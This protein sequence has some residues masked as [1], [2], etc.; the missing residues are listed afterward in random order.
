MGITRSEWARIFLWLVV[1]SSV[2][3]TESRAQSGARVVRYNAGDRPAEQ[4]RVVG[5]PADHRR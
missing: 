1:T 4:W 2:G 3:A 5:R